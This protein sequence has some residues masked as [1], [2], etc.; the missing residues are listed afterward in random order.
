MSD[1]QNITSIQ[2]GNLFSVNGL[3]IVITGGGSGLGAYMART[4]A[5]NGASKVFIIGR[6]EEALNRTK[7][8]LPEQFAKVVIPMVGDV[9][10][11]SSL[12]DVL[13]S[14]TNEHGVKELDVLICNSGISGPTVD[15]RDPKTSEPLSSIDELS[16]NMLAPDEH[17]IT[18]TYHVNLTGVHLTVGTFLPLLDAANKARSKQSVGEPFKPRPQIITT[19]SIGG[20]N[21]SPMANLSYGPS[22]AGV[23][24]LTKQLATVL[25]PYDIRA[26]TIA[27]GLY[28]S[29]MTQGK[30]EERGVMETHNIEGAWDKKTVPATR[31][32]DEED[33]GGAI[34]WLCSR[35]GGYIN[36]MVLVT[37]GGR[38]GVVPGSY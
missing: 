8:S 33:M 1:Q 16:K 21:R 28:L 17:D 37:D 29:E 24:H 22:K 6:R 7:S 18:N 19:S 13:K 14:V 31:S 36:G 12:A 38:M 15:V 23:I 3:N 20:L 32:G 27:P 9:S 4:L 30:Y 2:A 5:V 34:L 35:A 25:V 26:N 11:K 10:S